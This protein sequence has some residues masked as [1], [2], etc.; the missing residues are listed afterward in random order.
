METFGL[1]WFIL[2]LI[3][4]LVLG[5]MFLFELSYEGKTTTI[6]GICGK[7]AIVTLVLTFI[8]SIVAFVL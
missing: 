2:C 4:T 1:V 5:S 8:F 7:A 3:A 6:A